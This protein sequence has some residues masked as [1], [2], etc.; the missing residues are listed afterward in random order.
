[1]SLNEVNDMSVEQFVENFGDVAEHSPWVAEIAARQRPYV[2]RHAMIGAFADAVRSAPPKQQLQLL[3]AHPDL[4]GKATAMT[5]DSRRE[6]RGAGLDALSSEEFVRLANLNT[7]YRE[8]F[9]FPFI[10]AVK[11]ATKSQILAAFENRLGNSRHDEFHNA[12]LQV[13]RILR[14]RLEDRVGQ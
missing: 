2:D 10:F 1:M 5:G 8:R 4:A 14:F 3:C 9:G 12:L 11:E 6:Q 7:R 13:S